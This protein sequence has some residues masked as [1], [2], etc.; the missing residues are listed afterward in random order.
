LQLKQWPEEKAASDSIAAATALEKGAEGKKLCTQSKENG[1]CVQSRG[2]YI[3]YR[4]DQTAL[5][6]DADSYQR[7]T[8]TELLL[9]LFNMFS[10]CLDTL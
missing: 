1:A 9:C 3:L 4:Q 7:S 10:Q 5:F 8:F 2:R 6:H